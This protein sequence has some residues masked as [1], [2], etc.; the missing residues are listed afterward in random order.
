MYKPKHFKLQEL[1]P[2]EVYNNTENKI[3]LWF[4]FDERAL[5]T[6]DTLRD[7]YGIVLVNNWLWGGNFKYSG[8]R[9]PHSDVGAPRSQHRFGRAFDC[10]FDFV[11]SGEVREDVLSNPELFPHITTLEVEIGWFHFDTRNWD[12]SENGIF[13]V[14]P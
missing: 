11:D 2:P 4:L 10:K 12:R 8:Y 14:K 5:K 6:L 13:L 7:M 9:P 3:N 1:V